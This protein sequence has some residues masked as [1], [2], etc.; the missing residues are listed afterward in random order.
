MTRERGFNFDD[1]FYTPSCALVYL[2]FRLI[3]GNKEWSFTRFSGNVV[4]FD[5]KE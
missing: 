5:L 1:R 3:T 2:R 4:G